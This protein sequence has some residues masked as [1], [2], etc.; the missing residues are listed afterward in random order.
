MN[1]E[2]ITDLFGRLKELP[3]EVPFGEVEHWARL[4]AAGQLLPHAPHIGAPAKLPWYSFKPPLY[5]TSIITAAAAS[6]L[7]ALIAVTTTDEQPAQ[8]PASNTVAA[9]DSVRTIP[10]PADTPVIAVNVKP[11]PNGDSTR[12]EYTINAPANARI[13]VSASDETSSSRVIIDENGVNAVAGGETEYAYEYD[14]DNEEGSSVAMNN[15]DEH[16]ADPDQCVCGKN[17]DAVQRDFVK[18]MLADGLISS[19]KDY[20]FYLN[21]K[22]FTVNGKRQPDEIQRKYLRLYEK[23][24]GSSVS[25]SF[26]WQVQVSSN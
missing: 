15:A 17:D 3:S 4:H 10:L 20:S 9:A 11:A 8:Q 2:R 25:G 6:G 16:E 12:R 18:Q 21:K 13:T 5:M 1:E 23:L 19:D 22:K 24:N 7:A 26:S 14:Y